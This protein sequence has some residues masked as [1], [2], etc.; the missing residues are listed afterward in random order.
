MS[1]LQTLKF[2]VTPPHDC[3]YIKPADAV[4]LFVDPQ[5]EINRPTYTHL[6][7][8]GFRRSGTHIYRP[9][10]EY[11]KACISAR[12]PVEQFKLSKGQRRISN[13]NSDILVETVMPRLD[14]E[15]WQLY[16]SYISERH[17]DG[18]MYPP[19]Q[20]Q[21][22]SFLVET[23]QETRFHLF[24]DSEGTLLAVSVTDQLEDGISAVYTFFS[25][26]HDKRSLGVY[27]VLW[28]IEYLKTRREPYLY[29][30]YWVKSCRKMTYKTGFKPLEILLDDNWVAASDDMIL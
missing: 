5:A 16:Q 1:N 6:T 20:E 19:T 25:P 17:Q 4:T 3:S 7:Q 15:I 12:I 9:H 30:G 18:D 11:C 2:F 21:F 10:C 23:N 22:E 28:Q 13:K 24:R 26:Y 14:D 29:L 8:L 27:A